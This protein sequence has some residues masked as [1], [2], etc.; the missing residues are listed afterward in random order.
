LNVPL[1][2]TFGGPPVDETRLRLKVP[3]ASVDVKVVTVT[4][5]LPDVPNASHPVAVEPLTA[6]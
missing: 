4:D 5:P 2:I 3:V 1:A 6:M